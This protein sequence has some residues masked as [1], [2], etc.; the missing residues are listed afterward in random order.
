MPSL[1]HRTIDRLPIPRLHRRSSPWPGRSTA[2]AL[3]VSRECIFL[4]FVSSPVFQFCHSAHVWTESKLRINL[5]A[6]SQQKQQDVAEGPALFL[7]DVSNSTLLRAVLKGKTNKCDPPAP[8]LTPEYTHI[9]M[10]YENDEHPPIHPRHPKTSSSTLSGLT[11]VTQ[12]PCALRANRGKRSP[13]PTPKDQLRVSRGKAK[14]PSLAI[15]TARVCESL[16]T[17]CQETI[18]WVDSGPE[19]NYKDKIIKEKGNSIS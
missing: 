11:Q 13:D 17:Q 7:R 6:A 12:S 19:N 16:D 15:S 2:M 10:C 14:R 9:P 1:K 3:G 8:A 18:H 5:S 4:P